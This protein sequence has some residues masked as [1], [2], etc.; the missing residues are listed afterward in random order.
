MGAALA[1]AGFRRFSTYR[2]ATLAGLSTNIVFGLLR[3]YV[4]LAA[5]A[6]TGG[7]AAGYTVAQIGTYVWVG[8]GLLATILIWGGNELAE[9]V[10]SGD[11][12]ADLLRPV[13]PI[14]TDLA[15]DLGR[16]GHAA[17]IRLV[18]PVLFG[19]LFFPFYWPESPVSYPLFL[20]SLVLAVLL[21]FACRY[22]VNLTA[23]W[24]LDIRGVS[25]VWVVASGVLSGLY[26]PIAFL[27][28]WAAGLLQYATPFPSLMQ[29]PIDVA[30]ERHGLPGQLQ[31]IGVQA[32]WVAVMFAV[33]LYV[34]RRA[35]RR[36]VIQG[37]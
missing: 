9:R 12:V 5:A 36:L 37:G 7:V 13:N 35:M 27:P 26:F 16:A 25:S 18:I 28:G 2:Q 14:W 15:T 10:R 19:A 34:Q 33:A 31:R 32:A 23:F 4:L 29:F 8:Q 30:V 3:L 1:R 22:L 11:V 24:L 21:C 17:L 20:V 6:A